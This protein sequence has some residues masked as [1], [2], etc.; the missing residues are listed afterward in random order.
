[1]FL[2]R[3]KKTLSSYKKRK[4]QQNVSCL[5][6]DKCNREIVSI[7]ESEG[8]CSD[9]KRSVSNSE[10]QT[11]RSITFLQSDGK[12]RILQH[13]IVLSK[14]SNN[15]QIY[16]LKIYRLM[17][18]LSSANWLKFIITKFNFWA[19]FRITN[20]LFISDRQTNLTKVLFSISTYMHTKC[21]INIYKV[22][23][24]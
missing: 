12:T 22:W 5:D 11:T 23:K 15:Q 24:F 2:R 21:A 16:D 20:L 4:K 13:I 17:K 1:M 7:A 6:V 14:F 3:R 18:Y 10:L 19:E 9:A 8:N